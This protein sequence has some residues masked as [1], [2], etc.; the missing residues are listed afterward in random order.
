[1]FCGVITT[2]CWMSAL[3]ALGE[4]DAEAEA[5]EAADDRHH[6]ALHQELGQDVEARWR[7]APCA[8]PPRAPA[9]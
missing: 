8:C 7:R 2:G 4:A 9:R 1:M 5:E 3:I 6:D